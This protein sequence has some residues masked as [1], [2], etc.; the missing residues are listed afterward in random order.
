MVVG[1]IGNKIHPPK[2]ETHLKKSQK[3]PIA[4]ITSYQKSFVL[5]RNHRWEGTNNLLFGHW[6]ICEQPKENKKPT[7]KIVIDDQKVAEQYQKKRI[8]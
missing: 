2:N 3:P 7:L 8:N 1:T 4:R 5:G 6:K